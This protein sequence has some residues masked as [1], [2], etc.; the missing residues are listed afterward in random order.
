MTRQKLLKFSIVTL[1]IGLCLLVITYLSF[2]FVTDRGVTLMWQS[3]AG[4]PFLT[5]MIG[6]LATLFM[7]TSSISAISV[8]V[9]FDSGD[10]NNS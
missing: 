3:E 8:F 7:F 5:D 2:H 10:K 9:F 4:K 6:Q 1:F